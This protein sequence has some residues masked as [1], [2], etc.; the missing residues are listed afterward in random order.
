M[1]TKLNGGI[2]EEIILMHNKLAILFASRS[3][4]WA[5]RAM[6]LARPINQHPSL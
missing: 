6:P 1:T 3:S 4:A 2:P 5:G